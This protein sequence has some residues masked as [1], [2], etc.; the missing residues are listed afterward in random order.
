MKPFLCLV[1]ILLLTTQ[2]HAETYSWIDDN[3]TYNFTEDFSRVPKKYQKKVKRRE[4]LPQ[5]V[6]P[7]Q[8]P[9]PDKTPKQVDKADAKS[10][11]A[12]GDEKELFG[13]KSRAAWRKEM[14]V[15][16]AEL[17]GID[18]HMV[19]LKRQISDS[20]GV[21]RNQFEVLKK[22]YNDSRAAYDQKYKIYTELIETIRKAGIPV[23][24]KK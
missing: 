13:G 2:L 1:F 3:G 12:Q 6:K 21:S 10:A 19:Q 22:D 15:L 23:D 18:Q 11:V 20:K 14:D 5:N 17:N 4:D 7:Q 24:I 16:E 9:D 8:S